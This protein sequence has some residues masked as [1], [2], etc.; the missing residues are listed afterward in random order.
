[1]SIAS[2]HLVSKPN[3]LSPLSPLTSSLSSLL[4]PSQ[5]AAGAQL[6]TVHGRAPL[7]TIQSPLW[8]ESPGA[9]VGLELW[10]SHYFTEPSPPPT[11]KRVGAPRMLTA[12][13]WAPP[14]AAGMPAQVP[15]LPAAPTLLLLSHRF[16]SQVPRKQTQEVPGPGRPTRCG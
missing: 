11:L 2:V 10:R 9:G 15:T 1:M 12:S 4:E 13:T 5:T 16:L 7:R 6:G 3:S 14:P 8:P